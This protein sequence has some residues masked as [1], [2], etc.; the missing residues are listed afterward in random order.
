[1]EHVCRHKPRLVGLG[2]GIE[3]LPDG[4]P[5]KPQCLFQLSKLVGVVGNFV[6]SKRLFCHA[7]EIWRERGDDLQVARTLERIA[8][9]NRMV[10]LRE[11][12]IQQAREGL[13]ICE[14][15][16]DRNG[17]VECL[18]GLTFL[19]FED[20]QFEAAEEAGLRAIALLPEKGEEYLAQRSHRALGN[21][22]GG[23]GETDKGIHHFE[24]ALGIA[25]SFGWHDHLFWIHYFLAQLYNNKGS[26][27]DA[28]AH[29][30]HAKSYAIRS[31]RN[32][33]WVMRL[34]AEFLYQQSQ[35]EQAK[36]EALN[37]AKTFE[38]IGAVQDLERCRPF[39]ESID[40]ERK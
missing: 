31:A 15:L 34:Q 40:S 29:I 19:L 4:H 37:A 8:D 20:K 16:G 36:S 10:A 14:Q 33:A 27:D 25:S 22:Y 13:E 7:L 18:V 2:P 6:E 35:F 23:K 39:L 11:E 21:T 1:L 17:Q 32:M 26:F 12:G 28:N 9:T 3:G 5:S 38:R 24:I 30:E